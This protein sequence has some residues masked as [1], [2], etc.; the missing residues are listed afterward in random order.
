MIR[1]ALRVLSKSPG[2]SA[3]VLLV[4]A[5]GIGATTTIFSVVDGVL[6][7]PLPYGNASRLIRIVNITRG[8]ET[9]DVSYPDFVDWRAQAKSIDAWPG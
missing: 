2:F 7:K 5:I 1:H 8:E 3:L 6:L 4:L 9:G